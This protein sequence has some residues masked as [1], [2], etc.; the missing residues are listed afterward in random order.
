MQVYRELRIL[1]ARP[2]PAGRSACAAPA[3][4]RASGGRGRQRRLVAGAA[5]A[6]MDGARAAGRLPILTGGTGLYFAALTDGLAEIPDPGAEARAE[7]R[8]LLAE[9][10]P[11]ALHASLAKVDPGDRGA[12]AAD[13]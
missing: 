5:L 3:V 1:T 8:R 13:R 4:W 9:H 12:A 7:A 2:S 6:A 10:G 11:A